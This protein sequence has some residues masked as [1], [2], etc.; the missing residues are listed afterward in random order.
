MCEG[1]SSGVSGSFREVS[2]KLQECLKKVERVFQDSSKSVLRGFQG[3]L[4][5]LW[6]FWEVFNGV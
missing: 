3:Y 1:N 4:K 5:E 6:C 2:G